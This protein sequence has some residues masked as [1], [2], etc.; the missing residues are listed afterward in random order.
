M[1]TPR[2]GTPVDLTEVFDRVSDGILAVDADWVVTFANAAGARSTNVRADEIVGRPIWQAFPGLRDSAFGAFFRESFDSQSAGEL[3]ALYPPLDA[4]FSVRTFP[5]PE[6]MTIY[7]RDVTEVRQLADE[8]ERLRRAELDAHAERARFESL[9]EESSDFIAIADLDGTVRYVNPAGLALV[10]LPGDADVTAT[11]IAD[12]LTPEGLRAS[13]EVEQPAVVR[14]GR[15]S[16]Q[17]TL[18]DQRGGPPIPVAVS[19]FLMRDP[20]TGV[21]FALATVQ[22]DLREITAAA[23]RLRALAAERSALLERLVVAQEEERSRIA[24][25]VHDDSVQ[26]L[27]ALGLRLG[28]LRKRLAI[29]PT[30]GTEVVDTVAELQASVAA[31]T[32]RLRH[33]LFDLEPAEAQRPLPDALADAARH[34]LDPAGIAW[35][36]DVEPGVEIENAERV[37]AMR[38]AKEALANARDHSGARTVR[39]TARR[40]DDATE[41]SVADDG[42]GFDPAAA[43]PRPGH[44][45]LQTMRDRVEIAG[46]RFD[47]ESPAGGGTVVRFRLPGRRR[48]DTS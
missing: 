17:S 29:L 18:R 30:A 41:L 8:R 26:A 28:L 40:V 23:E 36:V 34:V 42:A 19:S 46:G 47:L 33:L 37:V 32:E 3:E 45:G 31:A 4:W 2:T 11:T 25:D 7:F 1:T 20:V 9:V 13:V 38:V 12:Y 24:A 21:P 14:D 35:Q 43:V 44:R 22:R 39:I 27:A 48:D 5:S 15:W 6:G 10:G 16:G